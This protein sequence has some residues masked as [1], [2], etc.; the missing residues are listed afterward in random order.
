MLIFA[1]YH[2]YILS[3]IN[4]NFFTITQFLYQSVSLIFIIALLIKSKFQS[5]LFYNNGIITAFLTISFGF[6]IYQRDIDYNLLFFVIL[7]YIVLF[8]KNFYSLNIKNFLFKNII[9]IFLI[10]LIEIIFNEAY[11]NFTNIHSYYLNTREW[12]QGNTKNIDYYAGISRTSGNYFLNIINYRISSIFIEP[13]SLSYFC[14]ISFIFYN[15]QDDTNKTVNYKKIIFNL[16][17][18]FL[19]IVSDTRSALFFLFIL[20]LPNRIFKIKNL[21][22][23]LFLSLFIYL[24]FLVYGLNNDE[25]IFRI[26]HSKI[27]DV[28]LL[29]LIN[30]KAYYYNEFYDS[31]YVNIFMNFG[32]FGFFLIFYLLI[33]L[34]NHLKNINSDKLVLLNKCLIYFIFFNLF[35]SAVYSIKTTLLLFYFINFYFIE[36]ID[37]KKISIERK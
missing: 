4:N 19:I 3:I 6:S 12:Y 24:Y 7:T 22:I 11:Y 35:G 30:L 9:I 27:S 2:N 15:Y 16:I 36:L 21:P 23:I 34:P 26:S 32:I 10:A 28:S 17:I 25:F 14:I 5:Y 8:N 31:G 13:L 1:I 29:Q 37:K 20:F 18:F 33:K